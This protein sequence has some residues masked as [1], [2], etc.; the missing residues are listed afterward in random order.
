MMQALREREEEAKRKENARKIANLFSGS[1]LTDKFKK[2]TFSNWQD[3]PNTKN[4]LELAKSYISNFE[5]FRAE[6]QGIILFSKTK[7]NGKSHLTGA[8]ANHLLNSGV[9]VVFINVPEFFDKLMACWNGHGDEH[10]LKTALI[11]CELL[12]LDDLGANKYTERKEEEM[13]KIINAR[14]SRNKPIIASTNC[15]LDGLEA[16]LGER[17]FSRLLEMTSVF[18]ENRSSDFRRESKLPS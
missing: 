10:T 16:N 15:T 8:I 18:M 4:M 6:G 1:M 2:Y 3:R 13:Y 14:Y 17:T 7:G 5:K 11:N 12:I 9:S